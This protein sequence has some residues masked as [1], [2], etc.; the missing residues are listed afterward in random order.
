MS[1]QLIEPFVDSARYI[2]VYDATGHLV[3]YIEGPKAEEKIKK[4]QIT[5][6]DWAR[7][8]RCHI[9]SRLWKGRSAQNFFGLFVTIC[10]ASRKLHAAA[11]RWRTSDRLGARC[12][13]DVTQL[14]AAARNC[15]L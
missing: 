3:R 4:L 8:N 11:R 10:H 1:G 6:S 15:T 9:M 14:H 7:E 2:P 5:L 13:A 12:H